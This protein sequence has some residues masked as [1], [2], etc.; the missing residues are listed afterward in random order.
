VTGDS[1]SAQAQ[2]RFDLN[3]PIYTAPAF[4]TL[5]AGT[6]VSQMD[7][8]LE[9]L[10]DSTITVR[11]IGA[12][13]AGGSGIADYAIYM[14]VNGG[15]FALLQDE[16]VDTSLT[17]SGR[18]YNVYEFFTIACDN[19]GQT[20]PMKSDG[21]VGVY[22]TLPPPAQSVADLTLR[23]HRD[24]SS[25]TAL[26]HWSAIR[27]DTLGN[28]IEVSEYRIYTLATGGSGGSWEMLAAIPDTSYSFQIAPE[29]NTAL[30]FF[31]VIAIRSGRMGPMRQPAPDRPVLFLQPDMFPA[32]P[33]LPPGKSAS[34]PR[35]K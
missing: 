21:D 30:R 22:F 24:G 32:A 2:I 27:E 28:P 9:A 6:P 13:D 17:L 16:L 29:E 33:L 31:H 23:V 3:D 18:M 7:S 34:A 15:P 14:S 11:W 26:L 1:I 8:N 20:E 12:D 4:N 25:T 19:V 35:P 5:D 10:N